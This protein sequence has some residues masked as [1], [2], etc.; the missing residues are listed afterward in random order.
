MARVSLGLTLL[1]Y[2]VLQ[3]LYITATPVQEFYLPESVPQAMRDAPVLAGLGPDEK[4][5]LL[6]VRSLAETGRPPRPQPKDRTSP[7]DYVCYQAQHP[8]LFFALSVPLWKLFGSSGTTFWYLWRG[9]CSVLGAV[10][11]VLASRAARC[12]FPENPLV[13]LAAAPVVAFVPMLGH[14]MG[15]V[16]NEPLAM[17]LGAWSWLRVVQHCRG[18]LP[19]LRE[20]LLLGVILGLTLLTR[21]TGVLW[22]LAASV[23]LLGVFQKK[24]LKP[25]FV[26]GAIATLFLL[27]W[28]GYNVSQFGKPLLRTFDNP[29]LADGATLSDF[30]GSGIR[31]QGSPTI[32]SPTIVLLFWAATGWTPFWLIGR[33]LDGGMPGMAQNAAYLLLVDLGLVLALFWGASQARRALSPRDPVLR[34]LL[35]VAGLNIAFLLLV[36]LQQM[37]FVDWN[38][39]QSAGRYLTSVAPSTALLVLAAAVGVSRR[40]SIRGQQFAG[41]VLGLSLLAA[42]FHSVTLLKQFYRD[43]PRQQKYQKI[44]PEGSGR[45]YDLSE[46][47]F[48]PE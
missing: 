34:V 32:Y 28:L 1:V 46:E 36:L 7:S 35:W 39:L 25:L 12:A 29:L 48:S 42:D 20:A 27:P 23:A 31:P 47:P 37:F 30:L 10:L 4:E 11:I 44:A 40:L 14:L 19:T 13:A 18:A 9:W 41:V 43:N 26:M 8:P 21:L 6:Y 5:Y 3:W 38:V 24:A 15:N 22:L 33:Y 45:A 17:A 16:S 2:C